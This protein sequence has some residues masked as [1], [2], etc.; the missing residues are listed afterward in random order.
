MPGTTPLGLRY[1][2]QG[3]T[4]DAASWQNLAT[5]IDAQMTVIQ[6]LRNKAFKPPTASIGNSG[7]NVLPVTTATGVAASF[8]FNVVNWDNAGLVNLAV[9]NDRITVGPGVWWVRFTASSL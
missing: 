5:D 2:L 1:P 8:L 7:G 6:G 9:N 3:E 4:V